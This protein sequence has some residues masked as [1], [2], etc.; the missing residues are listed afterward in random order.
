MGLGDQDFSRNEW[1]KQ[2]NRQKESTMPCQAHAMSL[3]NKYE[4]AKGHIIMNS[5][6]SNTGLVEDSGAAGLLGTRVN[7]IINELS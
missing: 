1:Y 3:V 5:Y 4:E 6:A 2:L 7:S